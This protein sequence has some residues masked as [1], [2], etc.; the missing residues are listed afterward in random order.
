MAHARNQS[1]RKRLTAL[2]G[3]SARPKCGTA[4]RNPL[5]TSAGTRT[6]RTATSRAAEVPPPPS[7]AEL[8]GDLSGLAALF[9]LVACGNILFLLAALSFLSD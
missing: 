7:R 9:V 4:S 6:R 5:H 3:R 2:V 8:I 1:G